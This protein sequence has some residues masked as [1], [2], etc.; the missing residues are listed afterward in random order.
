MKGVSNI[1]ILILLAMLSV[2]I[3]YMVYVFLIETTSSTT[4][5]G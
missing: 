1:L 5:S 2:S 4:Q 3:T